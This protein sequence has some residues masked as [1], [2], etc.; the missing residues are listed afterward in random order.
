MQDHNTHAE[1]IHGALRQDLQAYVRHN[2]KKGGEGG[3][4]SHRSGSSLD[5]HIADAM[6]SL[7]GSFNSDSSDS[8]GGSGS[9]SAPANSF[10]AIFGG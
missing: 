7:V 3:A 10:E 8:S 5:K 9:S 1:D 6:R 4:G 2:S